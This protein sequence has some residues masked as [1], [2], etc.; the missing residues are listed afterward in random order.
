MILLLLSILCS[1]AIYT[2]FKLFDRFKIN[3][4]HAIVMNYVVAASFGFLYA[5]NDPVSML[6]EGKPW[7]LLAVF[8]G[9]LFISLFY[10]MARTTQVHGVSVTG[11]ASKMSLII[12]VL[13]FIIWDPDETASI[14]KILGVLF[15]L[16]GII[17]ASSRKSK[18]SDGVKL[19]Y[20]PLV[21]FLG[22]GLLD[23]LLAYTEKTYLLEAAEYHNFVPM[24]FMIAGLLG[25]PV[26][27]FPL[28][29]GRTRFEFKS[30][31]AG[32]V[33]G[34]INYGSIYFLLKVLGMGILERSTVIPIN[35]IGVVFGSAM[36][37]IILFQESR[38]TRRVVGIVLSLLSIVLLTSSLFA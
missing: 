34:L 16:G 25:L 29:Q 28:I 22:S 15:G 27:A 30:I 13:F 26:M 17:L 35:N 3:T 23:L 33:L 1:T 19:N 18:G 31:L 11:I 20:M 37:G 32:I 12:P 4:F 2:V 10:L 14:N 8:V 36:V 7:F 6:S 21:L 24:P 9:V 5:G 38:S